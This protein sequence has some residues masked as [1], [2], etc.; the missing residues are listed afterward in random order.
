MARAN[1]NGG[2]GFI[3]FLAGALTLA[4]IGAGIYYFGGYA[5][6]DEADISISVGEDGMD[7]ETN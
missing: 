1:S 3:Y 5:E 2:Y 7:I 6:Q 4:V